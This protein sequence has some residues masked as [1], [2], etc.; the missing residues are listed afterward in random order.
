MSK[1]KFEL[2]IKNFKTIKE[3]KLC[4][5]ENKK[6]IIMLV[7]NNN[8]G[9]TNILD[10]IYKAKHSK[11]FF[12]SND[13]VKYKYEGTSKFSPSLSLLIYFYEKKSI[14]PITIEIN[15]KYHYSGIDLKYKENINSKINKKLKNLEKTN[16]KSS[17]AFV[18]GD[19]STFAKDFKYNLFLQKIEL[20]KLKKEEKK[21]LKK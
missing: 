7:G 1:N 10:A 18:L 3:L 2:I 13:K 14:I 4:L 8:S 21:I 15:N 17:G 12:S 19:N 16:Y 5:N 9:K 6:N 20:S 11:I